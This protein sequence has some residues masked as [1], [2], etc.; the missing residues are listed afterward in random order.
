MDAF[1][2]LV[3]VLLGAVFLMSA[4][5]KLVAPKRFVQDVLR[6]RVG[7]QPAAMA[8]GW[9]LPYMQ[10]A[11]GFGLLLGW[12]VAWAASGALIMVAS[13]IAAVAIAMARGES[14]TRS[15]F[16][17]LYRER[18]GWKTQSRD[19]FLGV[20]ALVTIEHRCRCSGLGDGPSRQ[21]VFVHGCLADRP[22]NNGKLGAWLCLSS[23]L[24][25]KIARSHGS[26]VLCRSP[27]RE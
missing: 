4:V 3:Q 6:Y 7:P 1:L 15:C 21:S 5:P 13:F 23:G 18:V 26:R 8:Y 11:A 10:L 9:L 2:L 14:L 17:L 19:A 22:N 16:G 24:A 25:G 20:L 27:I 12:H